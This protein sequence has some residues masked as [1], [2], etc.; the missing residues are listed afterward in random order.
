[1]E[2]SCFRVICRLERLWSPH[3]RSNKGTIRPLHRSEHVFYFAEQSTTFGTI[4]NLA[5]A[6]QF[7]QKFALS[8]RELTG[9]LDAHLNIQVTLPM[10][11]EDRH[12]FVFQTERR[13]RLWSLRDLER[14]VAIKSGTLSSVPSAAW[15][16]EIGITQR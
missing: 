6:A 14:V 4:L 15:E 16:N 7:L 12:A 2:E 8:F 11:I 1:Q 5:R 10:A 13:T 3:H 9:R